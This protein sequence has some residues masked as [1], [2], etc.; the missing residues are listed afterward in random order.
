LFNGKSTMTKKKTTLDFGRRGK[1]LKQG[2]G[3]AHQKAFGSAK[4]GEVKS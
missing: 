2:P 4:E 1:V 3:W